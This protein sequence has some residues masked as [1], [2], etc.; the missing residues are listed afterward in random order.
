ML[1]Y[2]MESH[3][4]HRNLERR[5]DGEMPAHLRRAALAGGT[6]AL[7]TAGL[8]AASRA[9]DR[10]ALMSQRAA[11]TRRSDSLALARWRAQGLACLARLGSPSPRG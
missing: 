10:M 7:E 8:G 6:A 2:L 4:L 9:C 3:C 1:Q 11:A 5:F